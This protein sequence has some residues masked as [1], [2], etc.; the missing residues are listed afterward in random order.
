MFPE[1]SDSEVRRIDGAYYAAFPGVKAYHDYCYSR[2]QEYSYTSNLFGIRYYGVNGH[3][4]INILIQGS[5][6]FY[7][8]KKIREVYD[9]SKAHKV[10]SRLQMNIHD[11]LSWEKHK[12]EYEVF[13][14]FQKIMQDWPD[15]MVPIVAEM[16]ATKDTWATKQGVHSLDELR[17]YFSV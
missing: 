14:E 16:D 2:A 13:F 6:A 3:K 4:L 7:L 12:T 15:A 11:E 17:L 8:K 5:S 10:K 1:K 9:Y